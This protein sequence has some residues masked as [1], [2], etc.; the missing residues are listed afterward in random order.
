MLESAA[1]GVG[2][3]CSPGADMPMSDL[4][5]RTAAILMATQVFMGSENTRQQGHVWS[6][7]TAGPTRCSSCTREQR[8]YS[9][10]Y[11]SAPPPPPRPRLR[12]ALALIGDA[13]RTTSALQL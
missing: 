5:F 8:P 4:H 11:S 12:L 10:P 7:H 13:L 9:R 2:W 3:A 6:S 1:V